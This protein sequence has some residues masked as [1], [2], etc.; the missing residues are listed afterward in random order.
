MKAWDHAGSLVVN[1]AG[2][3]VYVTGA[4][5]GRTTGYDY[6]TVAYSAATGR[7][8]WVRRYNS[9]G[10]GW[11]WAVSIAVNA[12]GTAVFVTGNTGTV[13]YSAAT[14]GQLWVSGGPG[15]SVVVNRRGTAGPRCS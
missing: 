6:A 1:A 10:S 13:A 12:A 5:P 7:Q 8:L 15:Y 2:T 3:R 9:P 11:D 14:G 4:S